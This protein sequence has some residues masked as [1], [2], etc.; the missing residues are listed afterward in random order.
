MNLGESPK[1]MRAVPDL[2]YD[3]VICDEF[4]FPPFMRRLGKRLS[5]LRQ[6][7]VNFRVRGL[8]DLNIHDL[9][10]LLLQEPKLP[11]LGSE[12]DA[13]SVADRFF[14]SDNGENLFRS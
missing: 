1:T 10:A 11:A 3:V 12:L 6:P 14:G 5:D 4:Q 7:F 13:V 9:L 2:F 8:A